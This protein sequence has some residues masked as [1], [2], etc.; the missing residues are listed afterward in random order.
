MNKDKIEQEKVFCKVTVSKIFNWEKEN[1]Y[2]VI[3]KAEGIKKIVLNLNRNT[4]KNYQ[5]GQEIDVVVLK[6]SRIQISD[7]VY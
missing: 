1:I 4:I 5:K 7:F 6:N 2:Q 3:L